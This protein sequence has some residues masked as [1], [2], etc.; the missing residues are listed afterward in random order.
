MSCG[1]LIVLQ[2]AQKYESDNTSN[3]I[4]S[5]DFGTLYSYSSPDKNDPTLPLL[6]ALTE[7]SCASIAY[8]GVDTAIYYDKLSEYY[9]DTKEDLQKYKDLDPSIIAYD[10]ATTHLVGGDNFKSFVLS[11]NQIYRMLTNNI[12]VTGFSD[13]QF[14]NVSWCAPEDFSTKVL[15]GNYRVHEGVM[16]DDYT[17]AFE[18]IVDSQ[19]AE[20]RNLKSGDMIK[21]Y[22]ADREYE[23]KI[24]GIYNSN[25]I[26]NAMGTSTFGSQYTS[27]LNDKQPA[28][29]YLSDTEYSVELGLPTIF[30]NAPLYT[31]IYDDDEYGMDL[32][33]YAIGLPTD[34]SLKD[35][36]TGTKSIVLGKVFDP[37]SD[38]Y[39]CIIS[40]ELAMKNNVTVGDEIILRG[41]FND[42]R[43]YSIKI[44]GTFVDSEHGT[45]GETVIKR[46]DSIYSPNI[47]RVPLDAIYMSY[48]ALSK[49][50]DDIDTYAPTKYQRAHTIRLVFQNASEMSDYYSKVIKVSYADGRRFRNAATD[51][52]EYFNELLLIKRTTTFAWATFIIVL[53][54]AIF[55]LFMYN[56]YN[57]RERQY[58]IGVMTSMGMSKAGIVLQFF[59]EIIIVVITA[60]FIGTMLGSLAGPPISRYMTEQRIASIE[61]Q[62]TSVIENF[63][64]DVDIPYLDELDSSSANVALTI[65]MVLWIMGAFAGATLASTSNTA[66]IIINYEPITILSSR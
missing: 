33:F 18:C 17:T 35:F 25:F 55:F 24:S 46:F 27:I 45:T 5:V 26:S 21:I 47:L 11:T 59:S 65:N 14:I 4:F 44:V 20:V 28:S 54:V 39:E 23:V 29:R 62:K 41:K 3:K 15:G 43:D 52:S 22:S 49:L 48:P 53:I 2:A 57:M 6:N 19:L 30:I 13:H 64:R 7:I 40:D 60:T 51:S 56:A 10:I 61:S 38:A 34:D 8:E 16:Y 66:T 36:I 32:D 31:G 9:A 42:S 37:Q 50:L 58:E 63:G 1:A 12:V